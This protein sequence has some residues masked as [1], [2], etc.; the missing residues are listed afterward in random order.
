MKSVLC[1]KWYNSSKNGQTWAPWAAFI[2]G[3]P[4]CYHSVAHFDI[5]FENA[6]RVVNETRLNF[7]FNFWKCFA[8]K[9]VKFW[10][11]SQGN[12]NRIPYFGRRWRGM[13]SLIYHQK[14]ILGF[15]MTKNGYLIK[16]GMYLK[17]DIILERTKTSSE[18][19]KFDYILSCLNI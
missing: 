13:T 6:G 9:M 10:W 15:R 8:S 3:R 1:T 11:L 17:L 16:W 12:Y 2:R 18:S 4:G 14:K 7:C 19:V 5:L